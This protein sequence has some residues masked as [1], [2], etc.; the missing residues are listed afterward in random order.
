MNHLSS[1]CNVA[2]A[3]PVKDEAER[4]GGCLRALAWQHG[5]HAHQ[6]VL[7]L[8][9]CADAT[10]AAVR[11][12]QPSLPMLV[13]VVECA[14][15]P[16]QA[17]AGH[18]R[19]LAME[20]AARLVRPDGVLLT[21]DA[22]GRVA[23]DWLARNLAALRRGAD[24][25][26]G[27]AVIDP[28]E[29]A[30]IPAHLHEDDARECAYADLLDEIDARLDPDP[31]DPWPRHSEH[32]G[33]SIAVTLDA[34]RRAGGVP[35]VPMGEDRAFVA[36]LRR[37]DAR[38]RHAPG[39]RV[40]VS[41]R[42]VG[43]AAGGMADTIRRR[44]VRQDAAV[45]DRLEPARARARRAA[46][47]AAFRDARGRRAG[48]PALAAALEVGRD[49]LAAA[50]ALPF[51]GAGWAMLEACSPALQQSPVLRAD[52]ARQTRRARQLLDRLRVSDRGAVGPAGIALREAAAPG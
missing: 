4:I 32:S 26:L 44:I 19:H 16:A 10:A 28:A 35:A 36:A 48:P 47:R 37:I 23:P 39:L 33:A 43:R 5:D 27:E 29:A 38:I 40:A 49:E 1:P 11:A 8:N 2:I 18:A 21:T 12:L 17:S 34:Y 52:L 30:L 31:A 51:A 15:P 9:N 3:I 41:G 50:L 22:D 45:D 25:V 20:Q 6:A 7:L 24:A 14:L 42:I 46:L 13:H